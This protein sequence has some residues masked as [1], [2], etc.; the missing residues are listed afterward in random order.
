MTML[1]KNGAPAHALAR[2]VASNGGGVNYLDIDE[3][4]LRALRKAGLVKGK[5][6]SG[7]EKKWIVVHTP[8]GLTEYR[9]LTEV[10]P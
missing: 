1:R 4:A 2:V 5:I 9:R 6:V 10:K 8:A 7:V 3:S